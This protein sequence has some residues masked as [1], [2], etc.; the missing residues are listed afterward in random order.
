M[1]DEAEE[2]VVLKYGEHD[3]AFAEGGESA[4]GVVPAE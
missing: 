1:E 2:S 3:H 4:Y